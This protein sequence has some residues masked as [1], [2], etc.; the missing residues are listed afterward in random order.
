MACLYIVLDHASKRQIQGVK[1]FNTMCMIVDIMLFKKVPLCLL[2]QFPR[3]SDL[4]PL[5]TRFRPEPLIAY[6]HGHQTCGCIF[7]FWQGVINLS[8]GVL[9]IPDFTSCRN[10]CKDLD[11]KIDPKTGG[12]KSIKGKKPP[13]RKGPNG[14]PPKSAKAPKDK[15]KKPP[16]DKKGKRAKGDKKRSPKNADAPAAEPDASAEE[17]QRRK[18]RA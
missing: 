11:I 17:P 15:S 8:N 6:L 12:A 14:K 1:N 10:L 5:E 16:K 4:I 13:K 18:R 7:V 9:V 3:C 2:Q